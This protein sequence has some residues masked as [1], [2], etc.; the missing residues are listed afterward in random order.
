MTPDKGLCCA[1]IA[2]RRIKPVM[3]AGVVPDDL[4]G[5]ASTML[6]K[7]IDHYLEYKVI[8]DRDRVF[9]TESF[10]EP[11]QP[12]EVF[13]DEIRKRSLRNK[14]KNSIRDAT[15]MLSQDQPDLALR[16]IQQISTDLTGQKKGGWID[17]I[18]SEESIEEFKAEYQ[19]RKDYKG[20]DGICTSIWPSLDWRS[21]GF[22]PQQVIVLVGRKKTKKSFIALAIAYHVWRQGHLPILIVSPEISKRE[23][24]QRLLATH[25]SV[26]YGSFI[27]ST[28]A[29]FEEEAAMGKIEM[30]KEMPGIS[31]AEYSQIGGTYELDIACAQLKP[32]FVLVDGL[33]IMEPRGR[34]TAEHARVGAVIKDLKR[35]AAKH[36][37][38]IFS[39]TQFN[40]E[41]KEGKT[42]ASTDNIGKSD[43]I[44][45]Y[46]DLCLGLFEYKKTE[47]IGHVA[48]IDTLASRWF[49]PI[50]LQ[51]RS[52]LRSMDFREISVY[53]D[54]GPELSGH[55]NPIPQIQEMIDSKNQLSKPSDGEKL[56]LQ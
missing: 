2:E 20:P 34:Y 29:D 56:D 4:F 32:K 31:V 52:D 18:F 15:N 36:E 30:L 25:T 53:G 33:Y 6:R 8:P 44:G 16:A 35:I 51:I 40:R 17:N 14:L 49:E 10:E 9:D 13:I 1:I 21:F 19:R 7:I 27:Q 42:E 48:I 11:T 45:Q 37:L 23:V 28:L 3:N 41:V 50:K 26:D 24:R 38:V 5:T 47:A 39:T 22:Q 55:A 46:A 43:E 12:L 54:G